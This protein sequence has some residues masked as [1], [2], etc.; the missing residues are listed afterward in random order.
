MRK[1]QIIKRI[2]MVASIAAL[3]YMIAI[4]LWASAYSVLSADDFSHG[5]TFGRF[6]ENLHLRVISSVRFSI[7]TY[8]TWQG[9]F[10]AM[11]IQA[12]LSPVNGLEFTQLRV[13]M[14]LNLLLII[15]SGIVLIYELFSNLSKE[16]RFLIPF[17]SA[18]L[19]FVL[20]GT[21]T[22]QEVFFWYSGS[23]SYGF[24]FSFFLL[25]LVFL[26]RYY[27]LKEKKYAKASKIIGFLAC[28]G[29][30]M[31]AGAG[32]YLTLLTVAYHSAKDKKVD[33]QG[34]NIFIWWLIGALINTIAPGNFLR[35]SSYGE[36]LQVLDA[37]KNSFRICKHNCKI[38]IVSGCFFEVAV[39]FLVMGIIIG[40]AYKKSRADIR[41]NALLLVAAVLSPA[42]M[43]F[44]C[45]PA[46]LGYN[47][48]D[49][50][51]NR[52]DFVLHSILIGT[53]LFAAA[54]VGI[55]LSIILGEMARYVIPVLLIGAM[56]S[57][58]IL[59]GSALDNKF[60]EL[61]KQLVNGEIQEYY[62]ECVAFLD[63]L[64]SIPEGTDVKIALDDMPKPVEN[65][66]NIYYY[67][68]PGNPKNWMNKALAEYYGFNSF[69]IDAV[70]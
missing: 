24:P 47:A 54:V 4:Y 26:F 8:F 44:A 6:L 15:I 50:L 14:I 10:F 9:T 61:R 18:L 53:T 7:M 68:D 12:L 27:R 52:C 32:C 69:T 60:T 33:K 13:V 62:S 40:L 21:T 38:L 5:V 43:W 70:K 35:K 11:F 45:F 34:R 37:I 2:L 42:A 23:T 66:I 30:L 28:G 31:I 64:D 49:G 29:T 36:G 39:I 65:T 1:C 19:Y 67:E 25:G 16:F 22:Y 46:T 51:N 63:K 57:F 59:P 48:Y 17:V 58:V 20:L 3:V 41:S 56:V 55:E